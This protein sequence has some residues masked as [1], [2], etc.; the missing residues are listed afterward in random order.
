MFIEPLGFN[1]FFAE[2]PVRI[3]DW[4]PDAGIGVHHLFGSN[5]FNLVG[6]GIQPIQ[7]GHPVNLGQVNIE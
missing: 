3:I 1:K 7:F 6:V 2:R 4:H 5:D